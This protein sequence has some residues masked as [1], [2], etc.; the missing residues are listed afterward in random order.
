MS[1]SP[2]PIAK[3]ETDCCAVSVNESLT[4]SGAACLT[5]SVEMRA[6]GRRA[7]GFLS[8]YRDRLEDARWAEVYRSTVVKAGAASLH[9]P[10][11]AVSV[12][13]GACRK[14]VAARVSLEAAR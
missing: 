13:L 4:D 3:Y 1:T 7:D 2:T 14:E 9:S 11:R 6:K 8:F 5:F 10:K 12:L